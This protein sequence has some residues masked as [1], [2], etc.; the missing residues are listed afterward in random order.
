MLLRREEYLIGVLVIEFFLGVELAWK[1]GE[2][3]AVL[4]QG[5]EVLTAVVIVIFADL[6]L[7]PD[8]ALDSF[9]LV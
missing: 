7:L 4:V 8:L 3:G 6:D 1:D 2:D 9:F 5:C